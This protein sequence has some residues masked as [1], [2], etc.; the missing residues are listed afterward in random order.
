MMYK[1][2]CNVEEVP[3]N[4]S[5]SSIKFQGHTGWKIGNLN[6]IWV[7]LLGRSQLSNPS[8]L[9]CLHK[10]AKKILNRYTPL[11]CL[12]DVLLMIC[13]FLFGTW[14]W[15]R[16]FLWNWR[17][18]WRYSLWNEAFSCHTVVIMPACKCLNFYS[19]YSFIMLP[20]SSF[21]NDFASFR[22]PRESVSEN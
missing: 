6:R 10:N 12:T 20:Y 18:Y 2:L 21:E 11:W 8:D 9:P 3:F 1:S 19:S 7:S 5:R 15:L 16:L 14:S 13:C 22:K 4:F 17:H